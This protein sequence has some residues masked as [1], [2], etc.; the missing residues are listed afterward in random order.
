[1]G[2]WSHSSCEAELLLCSPFSPCL[3]PVSIRSVSART[4]PVILLLTPSFA[5]RAQ[6]PML[7]DR[8]PVTLTLPGGSIMSPITPFVVNA[9]VATATLTAT[10]G[11]LA[12]YPN[13]GHA[14][15]MLQIPT[16]PG[17]TQAS[18]TLTDALGR[19]LRTEVIA[20]PAA[21]MRHELNVAG[22]P[23]T[24]MLCVCK[25]ALPLSASGWWCSERRAFSSINSVGATSGNGKR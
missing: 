21:D 12:L 25:P 17:T 19:V 10:Y 20:L 22:L 24:C 2:G 9:G 6:G 1:M 15:T 8:S 11:E 3:Y 18:L 23:Q 7:V 13:P 14:S 5:A 4:P 16:V